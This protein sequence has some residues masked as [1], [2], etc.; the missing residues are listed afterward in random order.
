MKVP[1]TILLLALTCSLV[2]ASTTRPIVKATTGPRPYYLID[3]LPEGALKTKL[4][5]CA[6]DRMVPSDFS[7]GH[8]GAALQF[9]EHTRE[10]YVAAARTGAGI[11]ECDVT[12]TKDKELVCRHAQNDLHTTT[13]ILLTPLAAKCFKP[14]TPY[15]PA[16]K[17]PATA[18]CRTTDITLAE[19]KTL[20]GKMDGANENALTVEE[21]VAGTPLFRTDLYTPPAKGGTLMTHKESIDLF[22]QLGVKMTPEAKEAVVEWPYDGFT[23]ADFV[24]KI[25]DEYNELKV[26]AS[27]VFIQSF[28]LGDLAY[29]TTSYPDGFGATAVYLDSSDTIKD[30]PSKATLASWKA[31][32]INIWAPPIWVL[33][34]AKDGQIAPSQAAIDAKAVGLDLI[35]W[36]LERSGFMTNPDHGGWYYQTLNSIIT[37]E[38]DILVA[39]HVLAQDVGLRGIFTDWPGTVTYYANCFGLARAQC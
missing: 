34:Q 4:E 11:I 3:N 17:S 15:D 26:N 16:T 1:A 6:D 2:A 38:S 36:S 31:S 5:S 9:P 23:R 22:K 29:L 33:L 37:R 14:F 19:F 8:R 30:V 10:S 18:E 20:V 32:G 39:L 13:N 27:D 7:I 25:V 35:A 28:I 21:Y 12:F 24:Q